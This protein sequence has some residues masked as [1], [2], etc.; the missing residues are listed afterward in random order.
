MAWWRSDDKPSSEPMVVSASQVV[1]CHSWFIHFLFFWRCCSEEDL[2]RK[3]SLV[4]SYELSISPN[5]KIVNMTF[6]SRCVSYGFHFRW[7]T[8]SCKNVLHHLS[9]C[10]HIWYFFI[11]I[12]IAAIPH[13]K[14]QHSVQPREKYWTT[15]YRKY[16]KHEIH[17]ETICET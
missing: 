14:L 7:R 10:T 3:Q 9:T 17:Y 2:V 4:Q 11:I 8:V 13:H 12:I 1:L 16:M 5:I 15:V 6:I